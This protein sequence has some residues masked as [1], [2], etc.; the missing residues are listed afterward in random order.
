MH[1]IIH[2]LGFAGSMTMTG[3]V[4]SW[5][6]GNPA[7]PV[8][9]DRFTVNGSDQLLIASFTNVSVALGNQLTSDNLFFN[10]SGAVFAHG[11]TKPKLFAPSTWQQ[12][13]SYSHWDEN[14]YP[15]GNTNSLMTPAI[16][17]AEAISNPGFITRGL[18]QDI[19]WTIDQPLPVELS[20][21][22]ASV[23]NS[24]IELKWTT[25]TEINN[26]GFEIQK[27]EV[28]SQESEWNTDLTPKK[29]TVS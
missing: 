22:L 28:R 10:G 11:G 3:N 27:K 4:G 1:E 7:R 9:Y 14:T 18:L 24:Y 25:E 8:I 16:G 26:Y 20:S 19:G 6:L 15:A 13:S 23:V 29:C 2:G 12:G 21:F 5:G 17:S